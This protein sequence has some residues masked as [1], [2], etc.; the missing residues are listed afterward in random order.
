VK[1]GDLLRHLRLHGCYL[2]REGASHSLWC[3]PTTAQWWPYPDTTKSRTF[4]REE[5]VATSPFQKSGDRR[6]VEQCVSE[7]DG[8][9]E[10]ERRGVAQCYP[11]PERASGAT[12]R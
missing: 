6:A 3:N 4:S 7:A 9:G 10:L 11:V 8:A 12:R 1:R 2:K 5:Y